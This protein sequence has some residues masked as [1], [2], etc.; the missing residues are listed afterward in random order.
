MGRMR[1]ADDT[2][3]SYRRLLHALVLLCPLFGCL[4]L[5]RLNLTVRDGVTEQEPFLETK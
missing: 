3:V 4:S 2:Y 1:E 5:V